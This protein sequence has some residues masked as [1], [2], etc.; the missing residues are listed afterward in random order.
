MMKNV[1]QLVKTQAFTRMNK[2]K[3]TQTFNFIKNYSRIQTI[4]I[5]SLETAQI[6]LKKSKKTLN[7]NNSKHII[8]QWLKI[9][10]T[11]H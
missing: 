2:Q 9:K 6:C 1:V 3:W 8:N 4:C 5:K 10:D 11:V 7:L